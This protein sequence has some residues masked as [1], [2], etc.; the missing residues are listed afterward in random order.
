MTQL[1]LLELSKRAARQNSGPRQLGVGNE[2]RPA[3]DF[4]LSSSSSIPTKQPGAAP[5]ADEPS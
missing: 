1:D 4:P 2:A 3:Q 5:S